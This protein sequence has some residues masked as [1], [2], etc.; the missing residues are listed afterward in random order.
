MADVFQIDIGGE[1]ARNDL[2]H[3]ED[4]AV[5]TCGGGCV[6]VTLVVPTT[7]GTIRR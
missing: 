3:S 7:V 2:A 4:E 6:H 5:S 1:D